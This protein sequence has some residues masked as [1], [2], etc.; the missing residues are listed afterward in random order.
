[1]TPSKPLSGPN[2]LNEVGVI[3]HED[4]DLPGLA[5]AR[6]VHP[7]DASK[8]VGEDDL[9]FSTGTFEHAGRRIAGP[10]A[11]T[12]QLPAHLP[13]GPVKGDQE[14]LPVMIVADDHRVAVDDGGAPGPMRALVPAQV[15]PPGRFSIV[16][17]ATSQA[18]GCNKRS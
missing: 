6:D 14:T 2:L 8:R 5:P 4:I 16:I 15:E 10:V 1:M 13:R 7:R 11:D 18:K 12:R 9:R 3:S 17:H